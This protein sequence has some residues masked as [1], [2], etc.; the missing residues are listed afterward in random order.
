MTQDDHTNQ[1]ISDDGND[2][3]ESTISSDIEENNLHHHQKV[4]LLG[5]ANWNVSLQMIW[6]PLPKK[7]SH[8]DTVIACPLLTNSWE[9]PGAMA[10][11]LLKHQKSLIVNNLSMSDQTPSAQALLK[12]SWDQNVP[13][14]MASGKQNVP[15]H[16]K[17]T[18]EVVNRFMEAIILTKTSWQILSDDKYSRDE[19][20]WKLAIDAQDRQ[21][22]LAESLAGTPSGGN[23]PCGPS[24]KI[25]LQTQEALSLELCLMLLY[26]IDD[27]DYAPKY[28]YLELMI[29]TN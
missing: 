29:S 16:Q 2:T 15:Q 8:A 11:P 25:D 18:F 24:L 10:R 7:C 17:A 21:Q 1:D 14:P 19:E 12:S 27:I 26:Q 20:V 5:Q 13:Q 9:P 28:T 6:V 4:L 23:V 22:A 3:G